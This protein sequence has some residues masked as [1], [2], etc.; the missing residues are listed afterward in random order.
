MSK[1]QPGKSGNPKG[2]PKGRTLQ[3]RLRKATS[4][5]FNEIVDALVTRAA[6]G[7]VQ[8][9]S[10]LLSRLVPPLRPVSEPVALRLSGLPEEQTAEILNEIARGRLSVPDGKALLEVLIVA[11]RIKSE[12]SLPVYDLRSATT[13]QLEA[14]VAGKI[15][16]GLP[17]LERTIPDS[18]EKS[19]WE[20]A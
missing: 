11:E 14:I 4:A 2:R 18:A 20:A 16:M 6:E 3:D 17:L 8:A 19:G 13:E 15:P 1:F 10:L 12:A 9:A 7:D 5:R